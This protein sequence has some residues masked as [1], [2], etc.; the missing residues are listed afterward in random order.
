[1]AFRLIGSITSIPQIV[2]GHGDVRLNMGVRGA[3]IL[4]LYA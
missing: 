4:S 3:L 2:N 1:M